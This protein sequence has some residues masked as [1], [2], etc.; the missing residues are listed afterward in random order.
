V[1]FGE[2]AHGLPEGLTHPLNQRRRSDRLIAMLAEECDH[3]ATDLQPGNI[4]VQVDAVQA[5][6]VEHNM[7]VEQLVNVTHLC[8]ATYPPKSSP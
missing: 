7:P 2:A 6:E 5:L 3:L 8:H 1:P 4:R